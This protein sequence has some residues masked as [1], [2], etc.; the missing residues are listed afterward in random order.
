[1]NLQRV[2][3]FAALLAS[4]QVGV[5]A[6]DA[7]DEET[8]LAEASTYFDEAAQ[9]AATDPKAAAGLYQKAILRFERLI[10]EGEVH[11]G[12]LHYNLGNTY[13][14]TGD[15]G[16]AILNYRRAARYM[17]NTANIQ[18][19]LG[20][21]RKQCLDKIEEPQRKRFFK[22]LFFWHYDLPGRLRLALFTVTFTLLWVGLGLRLFGRRTALS[23]GIG[24]CTVVAM[25]MGG[26]VLLDSHQHRN[27]ASGVITAPEVTARKGNGESYAP[28][29]KKPLHAGTEFLLLELRSG[30]RHIEL[31]DGRRTWIPA[32]SAE[33]VHQADL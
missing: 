33:Q 29:F 19:N 2:L 1:M 11:N 31:F 14:L 30:W 18:Q 9:C 22:T 28:S 13:Y 24:A 26:S 23:W 4:L 12:R 6:M 25:C 3:I 5:V 10:Q 27:D 21:A 8:L 20:E 16:R 32:D 15:L 17:P 7:S